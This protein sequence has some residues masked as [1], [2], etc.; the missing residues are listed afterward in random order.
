MPLRFGDD[1]LL[2]AS[3]LYYEEGLTQSEIA[4]VIGISR[5]S[6]VAYLAEARNRGIVNIA[7]ETDRLRSL[8]VARALTDHFGLKDCLIVPGE[9]G[10]RSLFERLGS[11]GAQVLR[12]LL[13]SGD[14]V[15]VGWGRTVL[16]VAQALDLDDLQDVRVVQATGSTAAHV[17]YTPAACATEMAA[18]IRAECI[19][20][21][22]PAILSSPELRDL[23]LQETPVREQL[24]CLDELNRIVFGIAS[25]RPNSTLHL[26]GFLHDAP[27]FRDAYSGA[28]G[29]IVGRYIDDMGRPVEGPLDARTVGITLDGLARVRQRIAIAG[30]IDKVPAIL[31]TLRG[32]YANVL[33]TDATT[34]M[35]VLTADG[36]SDLVPRLPK[37]PVDAV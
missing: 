25:V 27:Q 1:P 11:A 16:A 17:P 37:R 4:S 33:V 23:L 6:V 9:G 29:A 35:G 10:G 12:G 20:L 36:Q 22:A 32:G 24:A 21:S 5:A 18:A 2:W 28:V 14:T 7:I 26:S 13:R 34:G 8:S 15:G 3:W 19:P 31:A 30:G